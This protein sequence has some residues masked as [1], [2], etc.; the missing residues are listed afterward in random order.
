VFS[1]PNVGTDMSTYRIERDRGIK[2]YRQQL[3]E[4][5]QKWPL[6]FP[7]HDEDVRPLAVDAAQEIAVVMGWS[8]PYTLG[9]LSRWKMAPL[10]CQAVLSHDQ[11]IAL[12]G[13]PA[14]MVGPKAKDLATKHLARRAASTTATAKSAAPTAVKPKRANAR[15]ETPKQLRDRVRA[16]LLRRRV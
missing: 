1:P 12:D 14:E 11:R 8:Y 7:V 6:A 3:T 16:S 4:L 13:S 15:P 10:Y 2:E 5:R 9:V